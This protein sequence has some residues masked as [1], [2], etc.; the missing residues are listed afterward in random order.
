[1]GLQELAQVERAF[2]SLKSLDLLIPSIR[3]INHRTEERVPAHIFLCLFAY[4]MEWHLRRVGAA[5][6]RG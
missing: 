6:V 4:Y 2:R 3:P 5:A 1:V